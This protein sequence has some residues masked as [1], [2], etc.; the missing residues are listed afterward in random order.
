MSFRRWFHSPRARRGLAAAVV[1]LSIGGLVLARA[2]HAS[3][4]VTLGEATGVNASKFSGPGVEGMLALGQSKV[5]AAGERRVYGEL[6]IR[7]HAARGGE[8]ERAPL[9]LAIVFDK[10]GSMSGEKLESSKDSVLKLLRRMRDDDQVAFVQYDSSHQVRQRLARVGDVRGRLISTVQELSAGGGTNIPPALQSGL[11][12]LEGAG[13]DR[14]RRVVL[15][16]DGLDSSRLRAETTA[17]NALDSKITV[18]ALG[19]GLDFDEAYMAGVAQAGRGNFGFVRNGAALAR[20]LHQELDETSKTTVESAS[21]RLELPDSVRFVQAIGADARQLGDGEIEISVGALFSGDE[22]RV[23]LE[24]AADLEHGETVPIKARVT[25]HQVGGDRTRAQL[26]GL[27][28]AGERDRELVEAS[29]D[30]A[31][32]A[33]ATSA[34]SSVR[35]M[36]AAEAYARGDVQKAEQ[37][38][39]DNIARLSAAAKAAPAPARAALSRQAEAYRKDKKAYRAAKP[40]S[41]AAKGAAKAAAAREAKN[42]SRKAF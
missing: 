5:L 6:T 8:E 14:V 35:Q 26:N 21:L 10:S 25:W 2:P 34:L 42:L 20:F 1:V 12:A 15:V 9:A 39:A 29:R 36:A 18:S 33:S 38:A 40:A 28:L 11:E 32:L 13:A 37:I 23:A 19:I 4:A 30:A 3:S 22:R 24:L 7:A 17:R 41:P 16:S 31:V 27:A